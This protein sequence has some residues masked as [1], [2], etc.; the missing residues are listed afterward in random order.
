VSKYRQAKDIAVPPRR[1][2]EIVHGIRGISADTALRLAQYFGTSAA[3]CAARQMSDAA[4]KDDA[5]TAS[6][7]RRKDLGAYWQVPGLSATK[8]IA[9]HGQTLA[10][11]HA[12][13]TG[14]WLVVQHWPAL[15]SAEPLQMVP[16]HAPDAQS[17]SCLQQVPSAPPP[18][19][20]L[21]DQFWPLPLASQPLP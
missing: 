11:L 7:Q 15:R 8:H 20:P 3:V 18:H 5:P 16:A 14:H 13:P 9:P 10:P 17:A 1:V 2:N 21:A 6:G 19:S 12:V 4:V